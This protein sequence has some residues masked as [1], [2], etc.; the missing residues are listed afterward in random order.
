MREQREHRY[1]VASSRKNISE[2]V[3]KIN[4]G[5]HTSDDDINRDNNDDDHVAN[6]EGELFG[7]VDVGIM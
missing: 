3:G 2:E 5:S 6:S 7:S 4:S 1:A